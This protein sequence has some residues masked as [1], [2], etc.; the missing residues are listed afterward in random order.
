[1]S[2]FMII[3]RLEN[4]DAADTLQFGPLAAC[5]SVRMSSWIRRLLKID[6]L[7]LA[8]SSYLTEQLV[9]TRIS[10]TQMA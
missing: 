6:G 10:M 8:H 7:L 9:V 5:Y 2:G 4:L 3:I 1:M